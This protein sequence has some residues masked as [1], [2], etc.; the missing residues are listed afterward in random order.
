MYA[1]STDN[2]KRPKSEI[3]YLFNLLEYFLRNKIHEFNKNNVKIKII[4]DKNLNKK[5]KK[6]LTSVEKK[7]YK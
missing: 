1:F 3:D 6:L 2:W 5:L 7:T 4:G